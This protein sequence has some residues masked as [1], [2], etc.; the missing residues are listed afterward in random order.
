[1]HKIKIA[2]ATM[3]MVAF[4]AVAAPLAVSWKAT[5]YD[6]GKIP[7][8]KPATANFSFKNTSA[9]PVVITTVAPSCG[10]TAPDYDKNPIAPGKEGH[11]KAQYNAANMGPFNKTL[12]VTLNDNSTHVLTIKGEVVAGPANSNAAPRAN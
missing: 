9:A 12:T 4:A 6:F 1:M 8:N 2:A 5:E 10:C 7:Q 3:L 11:I